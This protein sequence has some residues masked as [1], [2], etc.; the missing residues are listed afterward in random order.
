MCL[1]FP[2]MHCPALFV[3]PAVGL[4]GDKGHVFTESEAAA[5]VRHIPDCRRADVP[6]ANHYTLLIHD[7]PPIAPAL[8]E[9]LDETFSPLPLGERKGVR[10]TS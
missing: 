7:D 1:H 5:I 8:F 6:G 9:F 2:N 10:E 3:R 4:L